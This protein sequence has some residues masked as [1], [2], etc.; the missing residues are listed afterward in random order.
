MGSGMMPVDAV[1][2]GG[3]EDTGNDV[4]F[5]DERYAVTVMPVRVMGKSIWM[6]M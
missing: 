2:G 1:E 4:V 5:E 6:M 3:G